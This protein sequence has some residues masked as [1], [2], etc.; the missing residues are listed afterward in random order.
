MVFNEI[1]TG[2]HVFSAATWFGATVLFALI[3]GPT[4]GDFTPGTSN[5]VVVKMLPKY[6]LFIVFFTLLTPILG[7][8]SALSSSGGVSAV[9][10]T[11]TSFGLYMSVG[12]GLSLATWAV[13]LGVVY[14]TGTR[15]I[16]ITREMI[17]NNSP[18]DPRLPSLAM[19][20]KIS[21]GVGLVLLIGIMVCMVAASY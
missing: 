10:D 20:L 21:T 4:I 16:R 2:L 13:A 18:H 12:A 5:E 6:L 3:V 15:I 7:L 8:A 14:P 11:G 1:M 19:R 9:F 17:K